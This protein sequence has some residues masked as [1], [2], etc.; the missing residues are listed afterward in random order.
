MALQSICRAYTAL[1]IT[2]ERQRRAI[3][4]TIDVAE[5]ASREVWLKRED[6]WVAA[7]AQAQNTLI[8]NDMSNDMS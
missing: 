8:I 6:L 7:R 5:K 2:R 1:G 3:A 4:T